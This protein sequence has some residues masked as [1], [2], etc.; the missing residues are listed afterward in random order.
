MAEDFGI[1]SKYY[2]CMDLKSK[3][4]PKVS[5]YGNRHVGTHVV[6]NPI[7][8]TSYIISILIIIFL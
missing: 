2:F 3:Q 4:T 6:A 5:Y 1:D 7:Q 8:E